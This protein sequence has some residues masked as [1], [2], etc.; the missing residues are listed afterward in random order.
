MAGCCAR[1][2]W[3]TVILFIRCF[4]RAARRAESN[5]RCAP[6]GQV[7]RLGP[8]AGR[9]A[10]SAAFF[11]AIESDDAGADH[12]AGGV[13]SSATGSSLRWPA[14]AHGADGLTVIL[15]IRCFGRAAR[16]AESNERCAPTG[17]VDRL[18][19]AAGRGAASAAFF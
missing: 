6:S 18:G 9:G 17:Q 2:E 8:A 7:D 11:L 3:L 4:G 5:E 15:F 19:P 10:A 1:R 16:R 14:V 12:G 13:T